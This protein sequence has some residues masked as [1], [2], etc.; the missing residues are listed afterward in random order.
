MD[1]ALDVVLFLHDA[2]ETDYLP[3]NAIAPAGAQ[4]EICR[5]GDH[6]R[7][8]RRTADQTPAGC[9]YEIGIHFVAL[10]YP[11]RANHRHGSCPARRS[12][13][14]LRASL[15]NPLES[16]SDQ[17]APRPPRPRVATQGRNRKNRA[18]TAFRSQ[19]VAAP[20]PTG[21]AQSIPSPP[22]VQCYARVVPPGH[23]LDRKTC[24]L[25]AVNEECRPLSLL[26]S[27]STKRAQFHRYFSLDSSLPI[28]CNSCRRFSVVLG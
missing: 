4:K 1:P 8:I 13:R 7:G 12:C 6:K 18:L 17:G 24:I 26:G 16:H 22:P 20:R 19:V 10:K 5:R 21:P 27:T 25:H 11:T 23:S 15:K 14:P 2:G 3:G 28:A 9:Q